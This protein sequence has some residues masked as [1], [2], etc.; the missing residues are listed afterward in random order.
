[1]KILGVGKNKAIIAELTEEEIDM[2]T[3][4]HG[5]PHISGRYKAGKDVNIS[6]TYNKV[7]KIN[8][9]NSELKAAVQ[10]IKSAA[11]DID[12]NLILGD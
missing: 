8:R 10:K 7:D 6:K 1:M 3:G 5:K 9:K 12:N 2:I 11:D 4:V